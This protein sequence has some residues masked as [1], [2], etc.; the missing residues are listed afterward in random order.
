MEACSEMVTGIVAAENIRRND[1]SKK[2]QVDS[3]LTAVVISTPSIS[4]EVIY[5]FTF[6]WQSLCSDHGLVEIFAG[7]FAG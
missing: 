7:S 6:F 3:Q 1:A 4:C 2:S 5:L